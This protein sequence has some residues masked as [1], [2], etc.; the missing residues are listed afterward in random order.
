MLLLFRIYNSRFVPITFEMLTQLIV[1]R[2]SVLCAGDCCNTICY[3]LLWVHYKQGVHFCSV[4]VVVLT[5]IHY[6]YTMNMY[7]QV[8]LW[9]TYMADSNGCNAKVTPMLQV[10]IRYVQAAVWTC[11]VPMLKT[12]NF[13][14]WLTAKLNTIISLVFNT[15]EKSMQTPNPLLEESR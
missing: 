8:Y 13:P 10:Y 11:R 3:T 14:S 6:T 4:L 2:V 5:T 1:Q 9:F 12:Y 15:D 7:E